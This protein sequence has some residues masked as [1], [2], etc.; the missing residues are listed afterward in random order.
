MGENPSKRS[1]SP[2][3]CSFFDV[4]E[5]GILELISIF[6]TSVSYLRGWNYYLFSLQ[7]EKS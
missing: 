5:N 1:K 4:G 2:V 3:F 6:D 7:L